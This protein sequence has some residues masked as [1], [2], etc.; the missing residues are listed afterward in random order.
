MGFGAKAEGIGEMAARWGMKAPGKSSKGPE[1]GFRSL[2]LG[3]L[4]MDGKWETG[5]GCGRWK[6]GLWLMNLGGARAPR[7]RPGAR[8]PGPLPASHPPPPAPAASLGGRSREQEPA[9][10]HWLL[11]RRGGAGREGGK[12]AARE[13]DGP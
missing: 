6:E 13:G 5:K 3:V 12:D 11:R 4:G 9:A 1:H 7:P 8:R 2:G 10:A